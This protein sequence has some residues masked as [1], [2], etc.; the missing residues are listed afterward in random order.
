MKTA[1]STEPAARGSLSL[2]LWV[3]AGFLFMAAL[4]TGMFIAARRADSRTVPLATQEAK[5]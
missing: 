3:A 4:W 1:A 5:P 2:W